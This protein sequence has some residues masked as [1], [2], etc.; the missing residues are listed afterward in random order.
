AIGQRPVDDFAFFLGTSRARIW[1]GRMLARDVTQIELQADEAAQ[2]GLVSDLA[3]DETPPD[4]QPAPHM[5]VKFVTFEIETIKDH[6]KT[7]PHE[8]QSDNQSRIAL[9]C[10]GCHYRLRIA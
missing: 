9:G 8:D 1:R 3:A 6:A 10:H 5:R 2:G 4:F 7:Q